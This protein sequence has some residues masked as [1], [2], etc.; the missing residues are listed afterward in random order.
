MGLFRCSWQ[1]G[2]HQQIFVLSCYWQ[3]LFA[4]SLPAHRQLSGF[5]KGQM[6]LSGSCL[7]QP[8]P[9]D[10]GYGN[11]YKTLTNCSSPVPK[12]AALSDTGQLQAPEASAQTLQTELKKWS[13]PA[14]K[15]QFSSSARSHGQDPH[16]TPGLCQGSQDGKRAV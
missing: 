13:K 3:G 16:Q 1:R 10:P 4:L 11:K 14:Q 2:M 9:S 8:Q 7:R 5:G 6:G 12:H 15:S